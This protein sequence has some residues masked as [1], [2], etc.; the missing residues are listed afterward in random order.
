[1]SLN[2]VTTNTESNETW[3]LPSLG[4]ESSPLESLSAVEEGIENC[5]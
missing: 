4:F 3:D 5:F 2:I 1:M